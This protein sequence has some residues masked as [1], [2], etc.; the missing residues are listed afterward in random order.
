VPGDA[1]TRIADSSKTPFHGE[2][3]IVV[4]K[5][6]S[7]EKIFFELQDQRHEAD[8]DTKKSWTF[9]QAMKEIL[10]ASRAFITWQEIKSE[11]IA[12]EYLVALLIKP[13][14]S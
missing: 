7:L 3:P 5:L 6:R 1:W 13:R 2:D 9:V 12:Q 14:E 4:A 11:N 8:Y 10:A